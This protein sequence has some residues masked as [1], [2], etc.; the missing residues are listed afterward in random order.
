VS[1]LTPVPKAPSGR[2]PCQG[3]LLPD[4]NAS[5]HFTLP[6]QQPAAG[7]TR[8][9]PHALRARLSNHVA[10]PPA[11]WSQSTLLYWSDLRPLKDSSRPN[12]V[13]IHAPA[14]G[15]TD[16]IGEGNWH[17]AIS[18]HT[19]HQGATL[20]RPRS[21]IQSSISNHARDT[22]VRLAWYRIT[23]GLSYINDETL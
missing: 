1:K 3:C 19:P 7:T 2:L 16:P 11:L 9:S 15:T 23:S 6:R 17:Y 20:S 5:R 18:I 14:Q 21:R 22:K 4:G 12:H 13:S 8:F 10:S